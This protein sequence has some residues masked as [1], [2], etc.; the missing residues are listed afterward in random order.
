MGYGLRIGVWT[1][2]CPHACHNCSN[3]ELWKKQPERDIS[4]EK[5]F[6]MLQLI[7]DSIDGLT[8]SGGERFEQPEGLFE[9]LKK[10]TFAYL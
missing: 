6:D 8:I 7:K 1:I 3:P 10:Y 4:M 5:L 9:L 2:G